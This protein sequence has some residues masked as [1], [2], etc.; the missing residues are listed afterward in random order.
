MPQCPPRL[1]VQYLTPVL[2]SR[3]PNRFL[4]VEVARVSER[5]GWQV[6]CHEPLQF[7]S[8]HIPEENRYEA[9]SKRKTTQ[10]T[11]AQNCSLFGHNGLQMIC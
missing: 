6:Q 11:D 1:H 7:M 10:S 5:L 8:L 4:R 3:V 9:T 2:W